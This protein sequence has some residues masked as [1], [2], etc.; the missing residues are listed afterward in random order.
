MDNYPT[1]AYHVRPNRC[2]CHPETCCCNDYAVH[3][4]NG[5]KHSTCFNKDTALEIVDA[6][7]LVLKTNKEAQKNTES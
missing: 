7:N 2:N 1:D 4:P 3:K 6:L 5:E